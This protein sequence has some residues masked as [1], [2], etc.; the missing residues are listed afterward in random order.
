MQQELAIDLP[1]KPMGLALAPTPTDL[2]QLAIERNLDIDKLA[3]LLELKRDW[4]KDQARKAFVEA[5][6]AF[7]RNPPVIAKT[8]PGPKL[9]N[10]STPAYFYAPLDQ[11]CKEVIHALSEHGITHRW[12]CQQPDNGIV[13]TCILTH[14]LGHSEQTT[15]KAPPDTGP[16]RNSIQAVASTVTYLQRYTLMAATGLAS[17][18]PDNDGSGQPESKG[19]SIPDERYVEL[20]DGIE[21]ASDDEELRRLYT[22]ACK[23]A[24]KV[25]DDTSKRDFNKAKNEAY[26]RLHGNASR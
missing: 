19:V 1:R 24:D 14:E 25:G 17:G 11:V 9:G 4:D 12:E 20:R 2:L 18:I 15:L 10:G 23:E 3:K 21:N 26:R 13:V 22:A 7:K 16:G 6:N 8:K 5:M